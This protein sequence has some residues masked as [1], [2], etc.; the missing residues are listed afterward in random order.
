MNLLNK[1]VITAITS[2]LF[3]TSAQSM[4]S[5]GCYMGETDGS[6]WLESIIEPDKPL[7]I[8]Y[9]TSTWG[10]IEKF[11]FDFG[12]DVSSFGDGKRNR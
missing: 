7:F 10:E 4:A 3:M 9:N 5:S 2:V 1:S 12:Y 8:D 6:Q 11:D